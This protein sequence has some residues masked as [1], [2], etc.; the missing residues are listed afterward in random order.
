MRAKID[1]QGRAIHRPNDSRFTIRLCGGERST[2]TRGYMIGALRPSQSQRCD[3]HKACVAPPTKPALRP[4]QSLR[5]V[6]HKACVAS[7]TKQ[8]LSV[9]HWEGRLPRGGKSVFPGAG[10]VSSPRREGLHIKRAPT[11]GAPTRRCKH[12]PPWSMINYQCPLRGCQQGH[13]I[14]LGVV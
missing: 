9:S 8:A 7:P 10:R 2:P 12:N 14:R 4:S 11:R 3:P 6:A 5:C 1:V 13:M